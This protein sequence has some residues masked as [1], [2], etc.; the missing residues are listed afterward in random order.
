MW[1]V[2][3]IDIIY[4]LCVTDIDLEE[5]LLFGNLNIKIFKLNGLKQA[6]GWKLLTDIKLFTSN[7][8][9]TSESY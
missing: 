1:Y 7:T 4:L 3:N 9:P 8:Q 2:A 6:T 5:E